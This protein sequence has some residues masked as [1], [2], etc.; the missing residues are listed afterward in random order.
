MPDKTLKEPTYASP[1]AKATDDKKATV[2]EKVMEARRYL[3]GFPDHESD[4]I[5]QALT[6]L[7]EEI[8]KHERKFKMVRISHGHTVYDCPNCG[9][10]R[11]D[12]PCECTPYS[13]KEAHAK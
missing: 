3:A 10:I 12:Y 13:Q 4:V 11:P 8:K 9:K 2:D 7:E 1:S 5:Y 6:A